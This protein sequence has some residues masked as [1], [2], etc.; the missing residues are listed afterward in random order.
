MSGWTVAWL[1]W[2]A[3]FALIEGD[4]IVSKQPGATLSEHLRSWF[5]TEWPDGSSKPKMWLARRGA[6]ALF[7][8]WFIIHLFIDLP[9]PF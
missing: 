9:G 8:V 3:M 2:G 7:F 4:A 6:L 1:L 5:A